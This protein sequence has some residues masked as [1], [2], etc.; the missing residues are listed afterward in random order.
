MQHRCSLGN[1]FDTV[2]KEHVDA[3]CS[4]RKTAAQPF[5][6]PN[7]FFRGGRPH[8]HRAAGAAT[9]ETATKEEADT[10]LT[11]PEKKIS[12]NV[13][14]RR[15]DCGRTSGDHLDGHTCAVHP[16]VSVLLIKEKFVPGTSATIAV[17]DSVCAQIMERCAH[18]AV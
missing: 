3:V 7:R 4:L 10:S 6:K 15:S 11:I 14:S 5:T 1:P 13:P 2:A 8:N 17:I 16:I 18:T 9:M 12:E